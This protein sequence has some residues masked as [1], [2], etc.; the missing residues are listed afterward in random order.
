MLYRGYNW[1]VE[2]ISNIVKNCME[3]TPEGG[4]ISVNVTENIL[5]TKIVIEDNG[6]GIDSEDLP[7]IFERF[8]RAEIAP[9]PALA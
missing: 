9:N 6:N 5:F 7:H 1:S 3:H 8:Y 2:A 4:H